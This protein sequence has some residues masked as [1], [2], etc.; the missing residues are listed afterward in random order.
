[1]AKPEQRLGLALGGGAARGLAHVGVLKVLE[2]ED[3]RIDCIAGTS[4]GA[5][6]GA[7]YA[8]GVPVGK[9]EEILCDLDWRSLTRLVD[10]V[11]PTSGLLDGKKVARFMAELLPV[12]TFETLTIPLAITATDVESGEA[13]VIRQGDLLTALRAATAFPGIFSPVPFGGR[14]LVDGGLCNPVP[15]NV[16]YRMGAARVVGVCAIPKIVRKAGETSLPP[17][18]PGPSEK[19]G[20][21]DLLSVVHIEKLIGDIW[22]F[23]DRKPD[24]EP[25]D[26]PRDNRERKAPGIFQICSRSVAIM[27]NEINALRLERD[28]IDLLIRPDFGDISLLDFHRAAEAIRAGEK[29]TRRLLPQIRDLA[30]S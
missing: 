9:M 23:N 25:G 24:A 14:F 21:H 15:A 7:L 30:G 5:F 10:P 16:A 11:L 26:T 19:K 29:E 8:A 12:S 17:A 13:L 18:R 4:I 28:E 20:W 6:I 1:M 27:E 22:P 3:I 2:E